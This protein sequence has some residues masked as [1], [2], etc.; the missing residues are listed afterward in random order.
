M[1]EYLNVEKPF[2][3]KLRSLQWK[4]IDQGQGIPGDPKK[5]LRHHFRQVV[6]PDVFKN[7][8]RKIN[9]T[10]DGKEWLTD[11]QLDELLTDL[12]DSGNLKLH[13]ANKR[14]HEL[15]IGKGSVSENELTGEKSPSV[16]FIDF[17]E[18]K[19]NDFVAINQFRIDT[20]NTSKKMIIPDI[21][22][23]VNGL[24]LVVVE[25]KDTDI[26][27]PLSEAE[28]QIR[29]Y[30]NRRDDEFGIKEGEERL[31]HYN[32]FS[33]ITH[34]KEA[35]FGSI[36][37][38]FDY[39]YN[40]K[41]IFPEEYKTIVIDEENIVSQEVVIRGML[42]KEILVD[43][44]KHFTLF[45]TL[46]SGN[47]IKIVPRYQQ[48]RA[49]GKIL[50]RLRDGKNAN[51]RSGVVWHTQGSGKSLTM[52]FAIR[53]LRSQ[54]DLKDHKIILVVDRTNLEDQLT[55]TAGL[56]G[57]VNIIH[58]RKD[59]QQLASKAS[60]LNMVM[61][62]KFLQEQIMQSKALQKAF[63]QSG[64]V[65]EFTPFEVVNASDRILIMID[66]AHRT[67]GGDMGDN[68]F[69]A[70]PNATKIAFTGTPLLTNRHKKKTHERFGSFID[71]YKIKEAVDDRATLPIIYLGRTS[72]DK[73]TDPDAFQK[74]FE[75]IFSKQT[76]E[77]REEIKK[78]YGTM[79]AYLD[80]KDRL[81][82]I[83]N[84]LVDH[85]ILEI[86]PNGFK[87]M[88]VSNSILAACRYKYFI[89]RAIQRHIKEEEQKLSSAQD[90]GKLKQLRFLK[91]A[92][93]VSSQDNNE[94]AFITKVR[95]EAKEKNAVDNFKKSFDYN[96]PETG[97]AFICVCDRLL[98]GFDAPIA[99]VMY[100][101]KNLREHDLLQSIARVNRTKGES[102]KHGLIVDYYGVSNHLKEALA[103]YDG[104][105]KVYEELTQNLRDINK[106]FPVLE[107]RYQ[108]LIN[109]FK[110]YGIGEIEMFVTQYMGDKFKENELVE[111][112]IVLGE[113][114]KFRAQF[115]T[116]LKTFFDSLDLLMNLPKAQ[117][118]WIPSKRFGYLLIR[119][120]NHYR[121][122]SMDLKWAA[123]K[124]RKLI[125]E[126]LR[127]DGIK[128]QVEA[129]ALLSDDF[130]KY[131]N[132]RKLSARAKASEMEH[133]IRR[134]I[135]INTENDPA[136]YT[137][138]KER[139]HLI[140]ER[141]KDNWERCVEELNGLTRTIADSEQKGESSDGL[142]S[143]ISPFYGIIQLH[144]YDNQAIP[145]D[146]IEPIKE[147]IVQ[148]V[149]EL[150]KRIDIINFW[151]KNH[152]VKILS[153]DIDD[154]LD[155]CGIP[156]IEAKH[157][158]IT[159]ELLALAK[160]RHNDLISNR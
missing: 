7:Y 48:Y 114:I 8:V 159:T 37:A 83:A 155:F 122:P 53:K 49:V 59:L 133:A 18:W 147:I 58:K 76:A 130:P 69:N 112:V 146:R 118:Y 142:P 89:E 121:D 139:L 17:T 105:E 10:E 61:I 16:R 128:E 43:V 54:S 158:K 88:V 84:D 31:F 119:I 40:W 28:N 106:E 64:Q 99:Q 78:R 68:L 14:I 150:Q 34:G 9:L 110:D 111:K 22:L 137:K 57:K 41:D 129:I 81:E 77:E 87:A 80:N 138:F 151:G 79:Q 5:S 126:Y 108:R 1:A 113:E 101:D 74:A 23:F 123:P 39:Y 6:L 2:L 72:K 95:T 29:R 60:D 85:Y 71:E 144:V 120:K 12:T 96:K 44:L 27:E 90:P 107:S 91:V 154:L 117:K 45:M 86:L 50:K 149:E 145:D 15:L 135:K 4:V 132:S 97:I 109:L 13:E 19:N 32:L 136:L 92:G 157:E 153:G 11:Q 148:V 36:T 51:E 26:S 35:R 67:Q 46:D 66:E 30:S 160:K 20:P 82:K 93:I 55:E 125:D 42:N 127:S 33:I 38:D 52:A 25:A 75:D 24:P 134:H 140:L 100:L 47:E 62:H 70:F 143:Y 73:M 115:D 152:E 116:Y 98:T 156:E 65:P 3:D 102:K 141:F 103:I 94:S 63:Q 131:I 21:V 56:V 104:D 124:V